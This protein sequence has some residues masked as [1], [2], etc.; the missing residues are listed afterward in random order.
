MAPKAQQLLRPPGMPPMMPANTQGKNLLLNPC[1]WKVNK[2]DVIEIE[3]GNRNK[4]CD[5][6][7][8]AVLDTSP[9]KRKKA[10]QASSP[11]ASAV[12]S[13]A[14]SDAESAGGKEAT[15]DSV[16]RQRTDTAIDAAPRSPP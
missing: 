1:Q 2:E 5:Q 12:A 14:E 16:K 7:S 9:K 11:V 3:E 6:V 13:R 4:T 8:T 15:K 10:E